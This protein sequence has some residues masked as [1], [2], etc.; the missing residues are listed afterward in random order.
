[1]A[2]A[3]K[4]PPR[5]VVGTA[6]HIDH[7]KTALVRALTGIDTDRLPEEKA[8]GITIE[9]GF[10]HFETATG[11]TVAVVD[12]PGHE[13][14]IR[15]MV[16]GATGIDVALLV[17]AADEGPMPQTRE[18]IDICALLGI[19]RG[20]IAL[21]K[22]DLVEPE[23]LA[24][25]TDEVRAAVKGTFFETAPIVPCSAAS[26]AGLP[27]LRAVL[28]ELAATG[29]PRPT[30]GP[31]RLPL[32]RVFAV[33]GFG[34]VVT[35]TLATGRVREGDDVVALPGVAG[36]RRVGKVRGIEVHGA[37]RTEAFAGERTAVNIQGLERDEL[38]RGAVL[39]H[40][41]VLEASAVVD[42]ELAV[43]PICPA[44]L[45]HRA[46]LLF[47]AL[48]TQ[49]TA[50]L[51]LLEGDAIAPGGRAL[52]QLRLGRPAALLPGDRF[53]LRGFQPLPQH[54]TTIG[55]GR[56]V[57]VLAPR[58]RRAGPR[59]VALA[60]RMAAA[61]QL[62]ERVAL[63]IEAAGTI[64]IDRDGLRAR[65]GDGVKKVDRAVEALLARRAA[66]TFYREPGGVISA[67][68]LSEVEDFVLAQLDRLHAARPLSPGI[69]REEL[70]TARPF[71]RA[72]EP[73]IFGLALN[74]LLRRGAV[75]LDADQIRRAGFSPRRAELEKEPVVARVRAVYRDSNLAP[76]WSHEL[77]AR[78]GVPAG[79]ASAALEI[80]VRRGELVR[81]KPDLCFERGAID[82]LA[83]RLRA[84]LA[85]RGEITPQEWKTL[86]GQSRKYAIPLA[87]HFD[88]E[89]LTLRVGDIRRLRG[90]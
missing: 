67:E 48:T 40:A 61:A 55:G 37:R 56:I 75:E 27:A 13:R 10:A 30:E 24:L 2:P 6:G 68:A 72:L 21:T 28:E 35:G 31:L 44:P 87:E 89:K 25:V 57:R 20:A 19:P 41:G 73:R 38:A 78:L 86:T 70:R 14:F 77:A 66:V 3:A 46:E 58:R 8:R 65:V 17:V 62:E 43:L 60:A 11:G 22:I 76:P 4:G 47:H 83:E 53:I 45:R 74:E 23:W 32:D 88:A 39:A 5:L 50:T 29:E 85:A 90:G 49:E 80:L 64:G 12:V 42:V 7:G 26:G 51:V 36:A 33:K 59:D 63:E 1:V 34:T 79:E 69:A 81:V 18:H 52:A 84:A 9:L 82:A 54:G 15:A 16:A 71:T